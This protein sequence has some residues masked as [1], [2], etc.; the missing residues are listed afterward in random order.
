MPQATSSSV[1]LPLVAPAH[2][3]GD[4]AQRRAPHGPG[5]AHEQRLHLD[6]VEPRR[7]L[8]EVAAGLEVKVLRVVIGYVRRRQPRPS[9]SWHRYRPGALRA[10][11]RSASIWRTRTRWLQRRGRLLVHRRIEA[12]AH[13]QRIAH[14]GAAPGRPAVPAVDGTGRVG[15]VRGARQAELAGA[16]VDQ[17]VQREIPAEAQ[18]LAR[19]LCRHPEV[20]RSSLPCVFGAVDARS[21]QDRAVLQSS[22]R[23]KELFSCGPPPLEG[24]T[25]AEHPEF[26]GHPGTCC[27]ESRPP[28]RSG[29]S[30]YL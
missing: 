28:Q 13:G 12:V 25:C 21:Q 10:A 23:D 14:R 16:P 11:G 5:S 2:E 7:F 3:L 9:R 20:V 19:Q 17:A 24:C 26:G 6:V 15:L 4:G 27:T 8:G 22:Q 29:A 18:R 1:T 30:R